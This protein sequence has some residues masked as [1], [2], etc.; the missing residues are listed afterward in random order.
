MKKCKL[1]FMVVIMTVTLFAGCQKNAQPIEI[2]KSDTISK[3]QLN[4]IRIDTKDYP[5]GKLDNLIKDLESAT[6]LDKAETK[7]VAVNDKKMYISFIYKND[8]KDIFAFFK[9]NGKWYL[10]YDE[11]LYSN[12][13]FVKEYFGKESYDALYN[14]NS[15]STSNSD[16]TISIPLEYLEKYLDRTK[17]LEQIDIK[18]YFL[19]SVEYSESQGN[20]KEEAIAEKKEQFIQEWKI[21]K[22][23]ERLG[24]T[25]SDEEL[26]AFLHKWISW[27]SEAD[28]AKDYE[29]LLK[30]YNT[31]WEEI[32]LKNKKIFY[33]F[34]ITN[35]LYNFKL[36]RLK[37]DEYAAGNDKV[38]GVVYD[39]L[40]DYYNAY[41][42]HEVYSYE[43][44]DKESKE[45][46]KELEEAGNNF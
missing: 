46:L 39:N 37:F 32:I 12:V 25:P 27:V 18:D 10:E 6:P 44:M 26:D 8:T 14:N 33:Y 30:K 34:D 15:D 36:Y 20:T 5:S 17:D 7:S 13:D 43:L 1:I 19:D 42:K 24:L 41:L 29:A 22:E 28:N 38:G 16:F 2:G 9:D 40:N 45:F 11:N 35:E 3:I 31:D 21:Y 23:A 4:T